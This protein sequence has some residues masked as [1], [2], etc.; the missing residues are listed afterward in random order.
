MF[1]L[2]KFQAIYPHFQGP[3]TP[4]ESVAMQKKVIEDVTIEDSGDF[5]SH[6]G[7]KEWL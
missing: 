2:K 3:L 1:M 4:V 7:N 6:L 5:L